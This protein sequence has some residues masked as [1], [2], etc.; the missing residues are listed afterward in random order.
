MFLLDTHVWVWSIEGDVKRIG[1]KARRALERAAARDQI[2]VSPAS[3]FEITALCLSGRLRF[4]QSTEQ[5]ISEALST[6]GLRVAELT[7]PIAI[8]AGHIPRTTLA[9]PMDRLLVATARRLDATLL[10][11]DRAMFA[12]ASDNRGVRLVDASR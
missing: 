8:D 2:R 4:A 7:V 10:T 1:S 5:W 3:V 11:A 9:D 6:P 12:Y